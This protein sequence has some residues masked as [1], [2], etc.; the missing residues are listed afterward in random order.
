MEQTETE[1][2]KGNLTAFSAFA[3]GVVGWTSNTSL[4]MLTDTDMTDYYFVSISL[5]VII[6]LLWD[7][8]QKLNR[9]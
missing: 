6:G 4:N 8:A 3:G 1:K 2:K 7:I 5:G 9:D